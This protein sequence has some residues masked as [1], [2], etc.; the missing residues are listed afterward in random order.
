M[1]KREYIDLDF[2]IDDIF[3]LSPKEYI[4][5]SLFWIVI[6][7]I[8]CRYVL[9]IP[10]EGHS[11]GVSK[12]IFAVCML[13]A[14]LAGIAVRRKSSMY[15]EM[16]ATDILSGLG[17]YVAIAYG[18]YYKTWFLAIFMIYVLI[19]LILIFYVLTKK[20]R[21]KSIFDIRNKEKRNHVITRRLLGLCN[22]SGMILGILMCVM[23]LPIAYN[24]IFNGGVLAADFNYKTLGFNNYYTINNHGL[25]Y[26][27][28]EIK[29]IRSNESWKI[30]SP[31]EKINVLQTIANCETNYFGM[32]TPIYV[33][34]DALP[35]DVLGQYADSE[36][37]VTISITYLEEA[38]AEEVF[39]T[40]LHEIYHAWE[41]E[42]VRLYMDASKSQRK[43][44]IFDHCEEYV[45]EMRNY[46][47]GNDADDFESFAKYYCQY[48]ERDS[49]EY[50]EQTV[51]EYY[52]Q[53]DM[54][55]AEREKEAN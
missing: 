34:A 48:L 55:L 24:K 16:V 40:C 8:F 26:N 15:T 31:Q 12:V 49:R 23:M 29:K 39:D 9:F 10:L 20:K 19:N 14:S 43:L 27:I 11:A 54:I 30:L 37:L 41:H 51:Q 44:R 21:G 6:A 35:E 45:E 50:A 46:S 22:T 3:A 2:D 1:K 13:C 25:S 32:D 53:I 52:E 18:K 28:D 4:C 36:R 7:F 5:E 47:D 33:V 17:I 38:Y 42:L